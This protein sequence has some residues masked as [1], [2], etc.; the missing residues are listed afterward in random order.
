[1]GPRAHTQPRAKRRWQKLRQRRTL[2]PLD[3]RQLQRRQRRRSLGVGVGGGGCQQHALRLAGAADEGGRLSQE[4]DALCGCGRVWL[5][6]HL[7]RVVHSQTDRPLACHPYT[8]H[9]ILALLH[10]RLGPIVPRR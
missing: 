9:T 4:V 2:E 8:E 6:R 1:M 3:C 7:V 10:F 5:G